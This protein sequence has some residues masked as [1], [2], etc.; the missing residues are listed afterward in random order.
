MQELYFIQKLRLSQDQFCTVWRAKNRRTGETVA[1]KQ[2][3]KAMLSK[4][5]L[6]RT[7][8]E[9]EVTIMQACSHDN[10]IR[11]YDTFEDVDSIYL[12]LEYCEGGDFED[13]IRERNLL[14]SE[15]ELADWFYQACASLAHLHTLG[16]CH[17][18]I[19]PA[20]FMVA[21]ESTL[22]L[23]D[24][25][26]AVFLPVGNVLTDKCSTPAYMAPEMYLI[27]QRSIGYGFP[28]DMW[29]VGV[30]LYMAM[31][32]GKHPFLVKR[33]DSYDLDDKLL[34]SGILDFRDT[35]ARGAGFF[36]GEILRFSDSCRQF[37]AQL[38][39]V[40]PA[41]RLSAI[42]AC[43]MPWLRLGRKPE[44]STD[45]TPPPAVQAQEERE[46]TEKAA[47]ETC[48]EQVP[49]IF[50][51]NPGKGKSSLANCLAEELLFESGPTCGMGK[52]TAVMMK[53]NQNGIFVDT[54][55]LADVDMDQRQRSVQE[56]TKLLKKGGRNRI[57]FVMTEQQARIQEEDKVTIKIVLDAAPEI[58]N[59]YAIVINQCGPW[60]MKMKE[61]PAWKNTFVEFVLKNLPSI[62]HHICFLPFS[63]KLDHEE[64]RVQALDPACR[65]FFE[66][67]PISDLTPGEAKDIIAEDF[68][69]ICQ[70]MKISRA[71][72]VKYEQKIR[73]LAKQRMKDLEE[74]AVSRRL[75]ISLHWVMKQFP[76]AKQ[77]SGKS[78]LKMNFRQLAPL[79]AYGDMAFGKYFICPRDGHIDSSIVD[80]VRD[81][82]YS[83]CSTEF[84]S[85][86]WQY[87]L[88]VVLS[89]LENWK[90]SQ[91]HNF[92]DRQHFLWWCFY[93][94]NQFRL[95]GQDETKTTEELASIFGG[96]LLRIGQMLSLMDK[97]EEASY[98]QRIWCVYEVFIAA[99]NNLPITIILPQSATNEVDNI[100][101]A[102]TSRLRQVAHN[103]SVEQA[104]ATQPDD[105]R[106][107][108]QLIQ[109]QSSFEEVND[110]V[111]KALRASLH[112]V[113][114]H[115]RADQSPRRCFPCLRISRQSCDS[116]SRI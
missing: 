47:E 84:L 48:D 21:N 4:Q 115:G 2:K 58:G 92:D 16:I 27:P 100:C 31:F 68:H 112:E 52:T 96:Q 85:W 37:C 101:R 10:I 74:A 5:G 24:F 1:M 89:A 57:V 110:K 41:T 35:T 90:N 26:T 3:D 83:E 12:A 30:M 34:T 87:S 97:V 38:I 6:T 63:E 61:D 60:I 8:V 107:I 80:A 50:F 98:L 103:I 54:V 18:G 53:E 33:G 36:G 40:N 81:D 116:D 56:N 67:I 114:F 62:T 39:T 11:L 111:A 46:E 29:A 20:N 14:I 79:V 19:K 95:L 13:K 51:G 7:D 15:V 65:H 55:G 23:V 82:G 104:Q 25:V 99:Q 108:K 69:R 91:G 66:Q 32:G 49:Y 28:V 86:V 73:E 76:K 75:G 72:R 105:E 93:Q 77:F 109:D 45:R 70:Q 78:V 106:E 44:I 88:D 64:N 59:N 102:G 43:R 42:D 113:I 94:N 17:R 22:K 9:R 71:E